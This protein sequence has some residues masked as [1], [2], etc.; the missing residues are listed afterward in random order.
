MAFFRA[1]SGES[2]RVRFSLPSATA[3][4]AE[5]FADNVG[6]DVAYVL[7]FFTNSSSSACVIVA[8]SGF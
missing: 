4:S 3:L 6:A 5:S 1:A 2:V 7:S 8:T